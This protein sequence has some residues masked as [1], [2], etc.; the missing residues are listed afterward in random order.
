MARTLQN[1]LLGFLSTAVFFAGFFLIGD[2]LIAALTAFAVAVVQLVLGRTTKV[3]P[4]LSVLASL[5]V[6]FT[7]TG[8]SLRGDDT[9]SALDATQV[10]ALQQN[11]HCDAQKT[12]SP[13]HA[14]PVPLREVPK[15]LAPAGGRV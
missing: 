9:F 4:G 15:A 2:V 7:I 14:T 6:V 12:T 10:N 11:C 8:L 1:I 13:A 3:N 5:A